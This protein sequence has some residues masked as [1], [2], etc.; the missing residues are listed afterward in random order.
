MSDQI[1]IEVGR[2]MLNEC[3][4][5]LCQLSEALTKEMAQYS[6]TLEQLT[7]EELEKTAVPFSFNAQSLAMVIASCDNHAKNLLRISRD[8]AERMEERRPSKIIAIPG[9]LSIPN[10]GMIVKGH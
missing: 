1:T 10:S 9:L 2:D 5:F 8:A 3:A 7:V 4:A 6:E